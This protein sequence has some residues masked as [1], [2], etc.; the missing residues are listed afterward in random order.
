MATIYVPIPISDSS[1]ADGTNPGK[2]GLTPT[3]LAGMRLDTGAAIASGNYPTITAGPSSGANGLYVAAYDPEANGEAIFEIDAGSGL[4][5]NVDRFFYLTFARDSGRISSGFNASGQVTGHAAGSLDINALTA[6]LA[7]LL[8]RAYLVSTGVTTGPV[9]ADTYRVA[10]LYQGVPYYQSSVLGTA[11]YIWTDASFWYMTATA[12]GVAL[13]AGYFKSTAIGSGGTAVGP[14]TLQGSATGT[15]TLAAHGNAILA[16]FQPEGP[17]AANTTQLAGQTVIAG[18][19]VSFPGSVGTSTYAGGNVAGIAG[20][21]FPSGFSSLTAANIAA[22]VGSD[23]TDAIG[24]DV[25]LILAHIGIPAGASLAADVASVKTD[26]AAV[27]AAVNASQ[28][29]GT[30]SSAPNAYT[31]VVSGL[32]TSIVAGMQCELT[33]GGQA[34]GRLPIASVSYSGG[35]A[36]LTFAQPGFNGTP[37]ATD[38]VSIF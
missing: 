31:L 13:P 14:Y 3:V 17:V 5:K 35:N 25:V 22:A 28:A 24:A 11:V 1:V 15:P 7:A 26:T 10:G 12:P 2:S 21:T 34:K 4:S 27:V 32:P 19:S 23:V 6:T 20:V 30:V 9:T 8:V 36:T 33:S 37:A 38:T 18:S 16:A 29:T